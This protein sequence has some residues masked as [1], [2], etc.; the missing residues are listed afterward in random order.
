MVLIISLKQKVFCDTRECIFLSNEKPTKTKHTIWRL[1][2]KTAQ[3]CMILILTVSRI[4]LKKINTNL[5]FL[6]RQNN[7]LNYSSRKLLC[8][9]LIQLHFDYGCTSWYPLL[10]K[11]LKTKLQI[12]QNSKQVHTFLLGAPASW[13]YKPVPFQ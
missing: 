7:Y 12:A 8:N 2:S 10:S 1:L 9:A 13:S 11:S 3:Y 5:N 4:V 6:C